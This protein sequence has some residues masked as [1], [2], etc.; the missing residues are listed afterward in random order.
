MNDHI[1]KPFDLAQLVSMLLRQTG[2]DQQHQSPRPPVPAARGQNAI[3]DIDRALERLNGNRDLYARILQSFLTDIADASGQLRR[4]LDTHQVAQASRLLHTLKG[5]SATVGAAQL[6]VVLASAESALNG[7]NGQIEIE[8]LLADVEA[9]L[10]QARGAIEE[11]LQHRV[12][13]DEDI[14]RNVALPHPDDKQHLLESLQKLT[15]LLES[16]NMDALTVHA[17]LKR[18]GEDLSTEQW[19]QLDQAI[20]VLDFAQAQQHCRKMITTLE[21]QLH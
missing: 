2:R 18:T 19:H 1:G 14:T 16:S 6:A 3:L 15:F 8:Q 11:M 20:A 5:T 17:G 4:L 21:A 10:P 13:A 7:A 9:A 12:Q